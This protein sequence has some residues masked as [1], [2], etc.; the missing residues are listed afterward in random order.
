MRI[1]VPKSCFFSFQVIRHVTPPISVL[2]KHPKGNPGLVEFYTEFLNHLHRVFNK[3]G[4]RLAAL[5][6]GHIGHAPSLPTKKDSWTVGLGAQVT[7]AI[8]LYDSVRQVYGPNLKVILVGH[9]V[10]AWIVTQ[11]GIYDQSSRSPSTKVN[12]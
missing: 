8:E 6:R 1:L 3:A 12:M 7:S 2:T 4:T 5:A 11:V 10:G 9:S